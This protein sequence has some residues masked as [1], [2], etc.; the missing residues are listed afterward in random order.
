MTHHPILPAT[1]QDAIAAALDN[2]WINSD[3]TNTFHTTEAA[4]H[5]TADLKGYGYTV[6]TLTAA[7]APR[8]T[9][10]TP[11]RAAVAVTALL[12][13]ACLLAGLAAW[14]RGDHAW[15]LAAT[16]GATAFTTETSDNLHTRRTHR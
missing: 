9:C 13:L 1:P 6:T 12:A 14:I 11:S 5:I 16:I 8:C 7:A 4:E 15:A 10:P 2:Y 3:P